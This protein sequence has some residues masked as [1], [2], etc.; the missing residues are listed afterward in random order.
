MLYINERNRNALYEGCSPT[1][2]LKR[3]KLLFA[4]YMDHTKQIVVHFKSF[5]F[6]TVHVDYIILIK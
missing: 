2:Q 3:A 1:L 6:F 5:F 4:H